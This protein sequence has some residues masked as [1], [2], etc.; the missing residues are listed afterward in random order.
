M[1]AQTKFTE[2]LTKDNAALLLVD[3]QV[4]LY[5][6]IRDISLL[7]LKHN[8]TGLAKA[9]TVLG[10]P[11]VVTTV[12]ADGMWGP[13]ISELGDALPDSLE[14]IDR[15]TVNAWDDERVR[16]AVAATGRKK[17]IITGISLEVCAAF[18]AIAALNDDYDTYV[19]VD[20]SGTFSDTKRETGLLRMQQAGVI[21]SDYATLAVEMLADNTLPEAGAVYGALDMPFATLVGQMY[22]AAQK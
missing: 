4:G 2:R 8:V 21:L 5:S 7:E 11:I 17:L 16:A 14:I 20:A 22:A 13:V 9:A 12:G 19:A 18:P 1:T 6:G 3:H 15:A 10:V